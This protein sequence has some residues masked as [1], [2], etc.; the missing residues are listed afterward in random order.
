MANDKQPETVTVPAEEFKQ[1][2]KRLEEAEQRSRIAVEAVTNGRALILDPE[3]ERWKEQNSRSASERTQD[4]AD[5]RFG[6][7]GQRFTC[8]L[9][10]T[11]EDGKPGPNVAEHFPVT[12]SANSDVEAE[13]RYLQLMGI[14]KHNY[15]VVVEAAQA[16]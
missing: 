2:L 11:T 7:K 13:G 16:A 1:L 6:K 15:K 12:L 3:Y 8:R 10:S 14:K 5:K 9:D 4:I